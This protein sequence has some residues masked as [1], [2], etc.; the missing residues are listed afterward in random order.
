MMEGTLS[1]MQMAKVAG[2]LAR[3]DRARLPYIAVLTDP[4]L[5]SG[6]DRVHAALAA[7]DPDRR[8]DVVINLQGDFPTLD[9]AALRYYYASKLSGNIDDID[10]LNKGAILVYMRELSGLSPKQLATAIQSIKKYY[11]KIKVED[12]DI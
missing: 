2:A 7:L 9:P 1:L 6:S 3:L 5:P 12:Q 4:T 10:L 11:K 8:H